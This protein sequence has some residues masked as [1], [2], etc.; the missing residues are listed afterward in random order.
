MTDFVADA[1]HFLGALPGW[2]FL[3]FFW[4]TLFVEIPRYAMGIQATAA[5]LLLR[6]YRRFGDLPPMPLVSILLVG[7]NEE[8]SIEKC[9]RSLRAQTFNCFEIICVDDGSS[10]RTFGIMTRLRREGLVDAV[11]QLQ[12]RGGKASGINLAA[13]MATGDVF[14][15]VD[16]DCSFEPDAILE[17]LRPL[18]RDP[19]IAGSSGNIL[20][21]N[22]RAS[23]TAS[24]QGIEY[25][26]SISLGKAFSDS[27]DQVSCVSGA[28]GAFRRDA[29]NRVGGMDIGGGEDLDFTLRLRM[30]GYKIAFTRHAIC[31]TDVP[32]STY[33]L[34]RQ[35]NRWERDAFWIRYRKYPR[36]MNPFNPSFRWQEAAHEWDFLIFNI[37]PTTVFPFYVAWILV[38]YGSF[39]VVLLIC[40]WIALLPLD[41]ASFA[42]AALVTGKPIYWRLFPFVPLFG[43]Y[44]SYVMRMCR[45]YAYATELIFSSS[46]TDNYV[47]QKA[48]DLVK[49]R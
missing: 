3:A 27:L 35:R 13:R 6:D 36:L 28:F 7:H 31:Y 9:V 34:L 10:D 26:L 5:A 47:P 29:W 18:T 33:N 38:A 43:L 4:L 48:R 30:C 45:F 37:L 42:G 25:L 16:C 21:R 17:L 40:V 24:L 1:W 14:V 44:Q 49:W 12:L 39:G 8:A 19:K 41:V 20:V 32:D 23:I 2:S 22:W 15:V 11:A 46:L